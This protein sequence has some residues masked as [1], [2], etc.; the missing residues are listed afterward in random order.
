M[1]SHRLVYHDTNAT[2]PPPP[3]PSIPTLHS[4]SDMPR[5][6][7]GDAKILQLSSAQWRHITDYNQMTTPWRRCRHG[8]LV[9]VLAEFQRGARHRRRS[10]SRRHQHVLLARR[11]HRRLVRS[12]IAGQ[13][14]RQDRHGMSRTYNLNFQL[15]LQTTC[16][17]SLA[18]GRRCHSFFFFF[19]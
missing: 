10:V 15:G 11:L 1:L 7:C 3:P 12:V 14:R 9:G 5:Y 17:K 18:L 2:E 13:Q 19:I 8:V 6:V 4:L 16:A